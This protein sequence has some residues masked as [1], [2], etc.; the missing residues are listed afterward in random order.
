M[1]KKLQ[2]A[3]T[4]EYSSKNESTMVTRNNEDKE[5]YELQKQVSE[6]KTL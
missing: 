1:N 4:V 6:E 5:Q 3:H 2:N